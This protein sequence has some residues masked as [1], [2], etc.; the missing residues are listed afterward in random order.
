[1]YAIGGQENNTA[2]QKVG[3]VV[4]SFNVD[5][6]CWENLPTID[7]DAF[8]RS[9]PSPLYG[10]PFGGCSWGDL[11]GGVALH[12]DEFLYIVSWWEPKITIEKISPLAGKCH[13]FP[14]CPNHRSLALASDHMRNVKMT[15]RGS[16][17]GTRG[18]LYVVGGQL[19]GSVMSDE[20][21]DGYCT[22]EQ[23]SEGSRDVWYFDTRLAEWHAGPLLRIPQQSPKLAALHGQVFVFGPDSQAER[24]T[25]SAT[26]TSSQL[27]P[28]TP[29]E[30]ASAVSFKSELFVIGPF[31]QVAKLS[32][33]MNTWIGLSAFPISLL[34]TNLKA[35]SAVL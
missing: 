30:V 16:V 7:V 20:D 4:E 26:E 22:W 10:L 29:F 27:V 23:V 32:K 15:G 9:H 1:M 21:D 33:D 28:R 6:T 35:C 8:C 34:T 14:A 3:A 31:G 19:S 17:V 5:T 13:V 25:A 12:V 2:I 11:T 24:F 18:F